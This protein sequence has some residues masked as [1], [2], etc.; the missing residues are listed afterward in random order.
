MLEPLSLLINGASFSTNCV[1]DTK[2]QHV[3]LHKLQKMVK[4]LN[5]KLK[6]SQ[7]HKLM[8]P[9]G[10]IL[11]TK[12]TSHI[13]ERKGEGRTRAIL[14]YLVSDQDSHHQ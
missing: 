5:T 1:E 6:N 13:D 8:H 9:I 14:T 12:S 10:Q 2:H 3:F 7:Y 4:I 11:L